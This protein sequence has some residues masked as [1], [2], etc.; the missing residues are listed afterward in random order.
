MCKDETN[1]I[2]KL[3]YLMLIIH[4]KSHSILRE[5][6]FDSY[7]EISPMKLFEDEAEFS[8]YID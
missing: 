2:I 8:D 5:L 7:Y 6:I 4:E 3:G 1:A